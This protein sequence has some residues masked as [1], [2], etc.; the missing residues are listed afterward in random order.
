MY[1]QKN[2]LPP[3]EA[4]GLNGLPDAGWNKKQLVLQFV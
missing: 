2:I 3:P 1:V 4:R